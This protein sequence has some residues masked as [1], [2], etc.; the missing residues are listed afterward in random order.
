MAATLQSLFPFTTNKGNDFNV[1]PVYTK[2]SAPLIGGKYVFSEATTPAQVF[3]KLLQGQFGIIAGVMISANCSGDDFTANVNE[4]LKL[5]VLHAG[6]NT[7]INMSAYPFSSFAHGDNYQAQWEITS[8]TTQQE[9]DFKLSVSGEVDQIGGMLSNEL[10]LRIAFNFI[11][12]SKDK[13][14]GR[15][16][17]KVVKNG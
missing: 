8:A 6:N 5:Q 17:V 13:L 3:G 7:P 12:T 1:Y 9:E 14:N 10:E 11:R 16:L 15:D 2:F 4:S